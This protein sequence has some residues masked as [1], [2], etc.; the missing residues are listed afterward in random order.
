[1]MYSFSCFLSTAALHF[2]QLEFILAEWSR[3]VQENMGG[4]KLE[5]TW[6]TLTITVNEVSS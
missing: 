1:M 3:L 4:A 5:K 2:L 6:R